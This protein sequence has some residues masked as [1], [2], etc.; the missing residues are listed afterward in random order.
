MVQAPDLLPDW[1]TV[2]QICQKGNSSPEDSKHAMMF[3]NFVLNDPEY[4]G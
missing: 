3:N 2:N 4:E 1:P